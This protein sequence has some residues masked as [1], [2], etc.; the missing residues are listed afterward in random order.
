[1]SMAIEKCREGVRE[2]QTPFGACIVKGGEVVACAHNR[3]WAD[4]DITAH[5]EVVAI[6]EACARLGTVD[7][8][9]CTIYST[10]EPCP[11]CFS[12]IHWA[13]IGEIVFGASIGDA[14]A[15]GFRELAISNER[16]REMGRSG[17]RVTGGVMREEALAVF[18]EW[19]KRKDRKT[20]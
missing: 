14:A 2:G 17:V 7:L 19:A 12:A 16:M 8:S 11:M 4:T 1:M 15:A 9:G 6:R 5:A 13:G 20:Y 10:V 3:V 18:K